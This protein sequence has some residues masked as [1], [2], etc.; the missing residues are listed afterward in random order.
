MI[1]LSMSNAWLVDIIIGSLSFAINLF[2]GITVVYNRPLDRRTAI[3]FTIMTILCFLTGVLLNMIVILVAR[4]NERRRLAN[5]SHISMLDSM[6]E[7]LLVL[8]KSSH[9]QRQ[10]F[11]FCNKTAQKLISR[12]LGSFEDCHDDKIAAQAQR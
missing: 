11:L 7:G 6:H 12:A 5:E 4:L 10:E 8:S 1:Y 9:N 2:L 3:F